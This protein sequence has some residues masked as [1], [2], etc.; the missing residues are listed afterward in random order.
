MLKRIIVAGGLALFSISLAVAGG[1]ATPRL[2]LP[3]RQSPSVSAAPG[4]FAGVEACEAQMHRMAESNKVLA[5][6][7][8]A[9]RVHHECVTSTREAVASQ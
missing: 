1:A 4:F 8:N 5:A 9:E 7:Y 6:N 3:A 2:V